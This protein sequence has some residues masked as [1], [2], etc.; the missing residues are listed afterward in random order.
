M[1]EVERGIVAELAE[2][3]S[4]PRSAPL[5]VMDAQREES[6]VLDWLEARSI[7]EPWDIAPAL[8][9]NQWSAEG[10][11]GLGARL[12]PALVAP[13]VHW[14]G[15]SLA[16]RQLV[17]E[18]QMSSTAISGIVNAVKSYAYLDRAPVQN[19]DIRRSLEDTL[20]ILN[21][22]LK[23]GI[24]V[25][26]DIDPGLPLVEAYAGELNQV[27]TNIIDNAA[28]AMGEKGRL[29]LLARPLGDEVEVRIIDSGPGIPAHVLPRIFEPFFTTKAQGVGTGLGLHIAHNIIVARHHGRIDVDTHPGRTEFRVV[30]PIH[31]EPQNLE[32]AEQASSAP[33]P[34]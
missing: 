28:Q 25:V 29:E 7:P 5:S 24:E 30:L 4:E 2:D 15:L 8:V 34:N 6:R 23:H 27:W 19:V 12:S 14:L 13:V 31:P 16:A 9:A 18:I 26:R 20:T 1:S 17:A 22:K 21:H 32:T 11:D 10:L 33:S 3:P